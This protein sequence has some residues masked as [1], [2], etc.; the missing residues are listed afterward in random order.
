MWMT[1]LARAGKC[2]RFA[3]CDDSAATAVD[4]SPPESPRSPT[5]PS[6]PRPVPVRD[7]S[8]RREK[9]AGLARGRVNDG[10]RLWDA[11]GGSPSPLTPLPRGERGTD[12]QAM[13]SWSNGAN[14]GILLPS[15]LAGEGLGVRG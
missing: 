5:R 14:A 3:A 13:P 7:R 6:M 4:P 10:A 11:D 12:L 9:N 8:S 2:V 15:P 1:C